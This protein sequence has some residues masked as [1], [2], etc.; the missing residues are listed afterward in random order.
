MSLR[1]QCLNTSGKA[2]KNEIEEKLIKTFLYITNEVMSPVFVTTC[3]ADQAEKLTKDS[4]SL[5][6]LAPIDV[7]FTKIAD[8]ESDQ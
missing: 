5:T 2:K 3:Q 8:K 1:K 4:K 7:C 6:Q